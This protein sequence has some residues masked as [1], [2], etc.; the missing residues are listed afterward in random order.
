MAEMKTCKE[1]GKEFPATSE[2][3]GKHKSAK[4]GLTNKCKICKKEYSQKYY[5]K[6]KEKMTLQHRE[7][8]K[9]NP[10]IHKQYYQNNKEKMDAYN[11]TRFGNNKYSKEYYEK[12]KEKIKERMREY[13]NN[14]NYYK[15]NKE[16]SAKY[17]E[18]NKDKVVEYYKLNKGR[19]NVVRKKY[20]QDHPNYRKIGKQ[21]RKALER[22][23]PSTLTAEQWEEIKDHFEN[24]CCYC[25]KILP[26]Q[27]EHFIPLSN[28]GEYTH[29]NIIPSCGA[30]NR[31]K[32]VKTFDLWYKNY[33]GYSKTR[34]KKI[35][36]FLNYKY[37]VQQLSMI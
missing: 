30:C 2:Y 37:N 14:T 5:I 22:N 25:G 34:E 12:N 6:N 11:K 4:N 36:S 28:G 15:N 23:L 33:K 27:Q 16:R 26:L 31:S 13:S 32:G 19:I 35:L 18:N 3:F 21:K 9:N 8:Y 10:D 24:K 1:C 29:N 7:Y 20:I 17:Y